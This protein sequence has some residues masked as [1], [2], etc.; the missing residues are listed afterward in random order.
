MALQWLFV[1]LLE[2]LS[3][4]YSLL[5]LGAFSGNPRYLLRKIFLKRLQEEAARVRHLFKLVLHMVHNVPERQS[6]V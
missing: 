4:A 1:K 5:P 3:K 6:S 2:K